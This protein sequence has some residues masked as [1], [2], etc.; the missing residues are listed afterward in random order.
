MIFQHLEPLDTAQRRAVG[1]AGGLVRVRAGAGTGKTRVL[2]TRIAYL[3]DSGVDPST[4]FATT[5]TKDAALEMKGRVKDLIPGVVG[6]VNICTLHSMAARILLE[7]WEQAGLP[8]RRLN[9]AEDSEARE[10]LSHVVGEVRGRVKPGAEASEEA[11][12]QF[13]ND[14]SDIMKKISRWK[15][16]GI[17]AWEVN[18]NPDLS[19]EKKAVAEIYQ[20]YQ[21]EMLK[22]S[23]MDFG[24]LTMRAV[25]LLETNHEVRWLVSNQVQWMLVDEFQDT[26]RVQLKLLSLVTSTHQNLLVVGDD[27]Q[28]LYSFRGALPFLMDNLNSY[29][30]EVSGTGDISIYDVSLV[31]NRRCTDQVLDAANKIVGYNQRK[32]PKELRSGRSGAPVSVLGSASETHEAETVAA[33]VSELIAS[34]VKPEEIA[35]LARTGYALEPVNRALLRGKI[36]HTRQSMLPFRERE[37]VLDVMAYL[38]L[39]LNHSDAHAFQRIASRPARGLGAVAIE[40]IIK[41]AAANNVGF[42][43]ALEALAAT[44]VLTANA[45]KGV[46]SLARHLQ[47]LSDAASNLEDSKELLAYVLDEIGYRK[48][49]TGRKNAAPTLQL[50]FQAFR[51]IAED[52]PAFIDFMTESALVGDIGGKS[53]IGVHLGTIHGAKGLEWDHVFLV[54]FEEGI[55]PSKRALKEAALGGDPS[56]PLAY[57]GGGGLQEERRLAHVALT[58]ARH[59]ATIS[60]AMA[61]GK[62]KTRSESKPSRFIREAGL[63]APTTHQTLV[64]KQPAGAK[65]AKARKPALW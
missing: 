39:A 15:E 16:N 19:A 31:T 26:N 25:G 48:W 23:L 13:Q 58:R 52:T 37:E 49:A 4:I 60:F 65:K 42:P 51:E 47:V 17:T 21:T 5:F 18:S 33:R 56:N 3:I 45:K 1:S 62:G 55:L 28:S 7:F 59:T 35:I 8:E 57:H 63:I 44:G 9:I 43:H 12:E 40:T 22:R 54:A 10:V 41:M 11:N 50:S 36:P 29:L 24:D 14:L 30:E 61:R 38:K 34:G 46:L 32:I 53:E 6:K 27:D 64:M 20:A 2:T